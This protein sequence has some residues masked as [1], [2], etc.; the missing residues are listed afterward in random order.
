MVPNDV[1]LDHAAALI[2]PTMRALDEEPP[3]PLPLRYLG[4]LQPEGRLVPVD[5]LPD[6]FVLVS[7]STTWQRQAEPLQRVIDALGG[8]DAAVVVAPTAPTIA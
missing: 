7:F 2:A 5:H 4:P 8:L 6:R 3:C 1:L